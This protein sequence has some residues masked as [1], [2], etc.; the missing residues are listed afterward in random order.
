MESTGSLLA[1]SAAIVRS[2]YSSEDEVR[3]L[4][5]NGVLPARTNVDASSGN[6]L[7]IPFDWK[8]FVESEEC[9]P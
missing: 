3:L 9:Y 8:G 1:L 4:F 2:A 7:R 5:D 6:L